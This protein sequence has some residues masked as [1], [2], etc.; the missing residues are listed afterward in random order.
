[1]E[2]LENIKP[3]PSKTSIVEGTVDLKFDHKIEHRGHT[4]EVYTNTQNG[5]FFYEIK[6]DNYP[7]VQR[8]C[9]LILKGIINT[10]DIIEQHG[11][12][13][14]HGQKSEDIKEGS[15][16]FNNEIKADIA[17]LSLLFNQTDRSLE[18]P[19]DKIDSGNWSERHNLFFDLSNNK[20]YYF[21]FGQFSTLQKHHIQDN[22]KFKK[23][24]VDPEID[25]SLGQDTEIL[26]MLKNKI[27]R[28]ETGTLSD[29]DFFINIFK[30]SGASF[31]DF[32]NFNFSTTEP[33]SKIKELFQELKFRVEE[34]KQAIDSQLSKS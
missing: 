24:V 15:L 33:D 12:Y 20:M 1:M 25:F 2:S 6:T 14:S 28:L 21:D 10:A 22:K 27:M 9:S 30:K 34:I 11:K 31:H 17:L 5:D 29:F 32:S 18:K 7:R 16:N 26:K 4:I 3:D 8:L 19:T 13:Y 23:I